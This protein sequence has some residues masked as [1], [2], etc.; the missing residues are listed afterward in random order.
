MKKGEKNDLPEVASLP[1]DARTTRLAEPGPFLRWL[2]DVMGKTIHTED[3][4]VL[5]PWAVAAIAAISRQELS[6][7]P[8]LQFEHTSSVSRFAYS[9]G[10]EKL[11]EGEPPSGY[12][13][14]ERTVKL[15]RFT[16]FSSIESLAS[17][18]SNIVVPDSENEDY[19]DPFETR[20]SIYYVM[21]ELMRNALQHSKDDLGGIIVAQSMDKGEEYEENPCIQIAVA[22]CGVGIYKSL[23][24]MHD[25]VT[26][27][28]VALEK[29]ILPYHS[30][31]FPNWKKGTRQNAGLGLFFA[32]EIAKLTGG[33]MLI[34]SRNASL[35]IEGDKTGGPN[36]KIE[37][38]KYSYNGTIV[39][40]EIL[41]R[42]IGNHD[43]IIKK[44]QESA[45]SMNAGITHTSYLKYGDPPEDAWE[46]MIN[47]IVE[48]THK[49][50]EYA[51]NHI[52]NKINQNIPIV[53]NFLNISICTQSFV[54]ALMFEVLQKAKKDN[55]N[56]YIKNAE[57]PVIESLNFLESY[58][59]K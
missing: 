21:V 15:H 12:L 20:R 14:E 16:N 7:S 45:K 19:F 59:F 4:Y 25:D 54:H 35:S 23:S 1:Y 24:Q 43:A 39:V 29:S 51:S 30:G 55:V 32:S 28:E 17:D 11:V 40:F 53:F 31:A 5:Q 18:I 27:P 57:D 6:N 58:T 41:K 44:V 2:Q 3:F 13:D 48:D 46:L 22:D 10:L 52:S 49:A 38:H 26:S 9:L 56:I 8:S 42:G 36:N 34:S 50:E 37:L 47:G 33:R